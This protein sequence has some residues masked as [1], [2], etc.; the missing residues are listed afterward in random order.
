MD[1]KYRCF[2]DWDDKEV[3]AVYDCNS[4]KLLLSHDVV[5]EHQLIGD[6]LLAKIHLTVEEYRQ[7]NR[8]LLEKILQEECGIKISQER[9]PFP[10]YGEP[11][12]LEFLDDN[13]RSFDNK[14]YKIFFDRA[15]NWFVFATR[16]QNDGIRNLSEGHLDRINQAIEELLVAKG[17]DIKHLARYTPDEQEPRYHKPTVDD[18][19]RDYD[20]V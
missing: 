9:W 4:V 10:V 11:K 18:F 5:D 3:W 1:K 17:V 20:V 7:E 6:T 16:D 2:Y 15:G 13:P 8:R 19:L 12:P 14:Q